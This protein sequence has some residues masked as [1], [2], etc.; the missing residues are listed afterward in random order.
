MDGLEGDRAQ[1]S[2]TIES[3]PASADGGLVT[4]AAPTLANALH[5][6]PAEHR[7]ALHV[8][9]PVLERGAADIG[10][11]DLHSD[12]LSLNCNCTRPFLSKSIK[13]VHNTPRGS[14]YIRRKLVETIK[15]RF[16][17]NLWVGLAVVVFGM[18]GPVPAQQQFASAPA[19]RMFFPS[20]WVATWILSS[21]LRPT[22]PI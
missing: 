5:Q 13:I 20:H 19:N 8:I 4:G 14:L 2:K 1:P 9:E 22:S 18:T 15:Q 11:Q 16:V 21:R 3:A 17:K 7:A 6:A 12:F 10:D